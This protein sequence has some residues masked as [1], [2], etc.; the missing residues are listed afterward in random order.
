LGPSDYLAIAETFHALVVKGI[1]ILRPEQRNEAKRLVILI[2]ALYERGVKLVCSAAATP[3]MLCPSGE[4]ARE[5][6]RAASRMIEM[7]AN[8]YLARPRQPQQSG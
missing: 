2:D 5:F 3:D 4:V 7:Q 6:A 1:P 8:D